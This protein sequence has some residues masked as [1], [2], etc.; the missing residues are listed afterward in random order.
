MHGV[1]V[2]TTSRQLK[3]IQNKS[4]SENREKDILYSW[5]SR[6]NKTT[7]SVIF[8]EYQE[9]KM[10]IFLNFYFA[11]SIFTLVKFGNATGKELCSI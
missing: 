1:P 11:R 4:N 10:S 2:T 8:L 6:K 7:A 5:Y 3:E 9:Y